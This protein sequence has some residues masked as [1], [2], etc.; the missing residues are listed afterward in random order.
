MFANLIFTILSRKIYSVIMG[1]CIFR[2]NL[3]YFDGLFILWRCVRFI[4]KLSHVID[5]YIQQTHEI[6]YN[7]LFDSR[8]VTLQWF[9]CCVCA[10][11][12]LTMETLPFF[13]QYWCFLKLKINLH[14]H[15]L[16][17]YIFFLVLFAR[18][19]VNF[20]TLSKH[21]HKWSVAVSSI[22]HIL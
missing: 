22:P 20:F 3:T 13:E 4:F 1:K 6:Y 9:C 5:G 8:Q 21:S 11:I 16:F 14:K 17:S 18:L 7:V 12:F 2:G 15:I 19:F 10:S